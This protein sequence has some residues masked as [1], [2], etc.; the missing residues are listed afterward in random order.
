VSGHDNIITILEAAT[1]GSFSS[2]QINIISELAQGTLFDLLVKFPRGLSEPQTVH[3]LR[4]LCRGLLHMHS[5]S[6]PIAHRDIKIE[7]VLICDK[8]FKLCDFGSASSDTLLFGETQ[9]DIF[10][11]SSAGKVD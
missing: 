1:G 3:I 11:D 10:G 8:K 2:P 5:Q 9:F 7:N 6:P 4:D